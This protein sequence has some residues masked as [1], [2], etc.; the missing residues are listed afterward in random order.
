VILFLIPDQSREM[1]II[2]VLAALGLAISFGVEV[3]VLGADIGRQNTFFK[4][5]LQ[6]W[7]LFSIASG[8]A[9]AWL[10]NACDRWSGLIRTP[11]LVMLATLLTIAGLFPIMSTEGKTALRMATN[12]PH[13]LDGDAYMN[14]ATYYEGSIPM[15]L[16]DDLQMIHWMEDNVKGTPVIL[17]GYM[18]E[19]KLG[20]RISINTGLP[21]IIGWRFH[22]SQQRTIDPLPNI[23]WQRVYNVTAMYSITDVPITWNMLKFYNVQYIVMGKLEQ[24]IYPPEGLDKFDQMVKAKLLEVVYNANGDRIYHVIPGASLPTLQVGG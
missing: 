18:S 12:A 4:F 10:F 17:E 11:W 22:Q 5:Y 1:R 7:I 16:G 9:V 14:Y 24:G 19:Y 2:Y 13:S 8:V 23:V 15:P 3:V 21:T 6:I 20:A